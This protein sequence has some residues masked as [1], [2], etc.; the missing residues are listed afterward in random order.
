MALDAMNA[1]DARADDSRHRL[2]PQPVE[3]RAFVDTVP[4]DCKG[5]MTYPGGSYQTCSYSPGDEG[6]CS[7]HVATIRN[8]MGWDYDSDWNYEV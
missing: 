8:M 2:R 4:G 7:Y 3:G 5:Y 1:I 6:Y